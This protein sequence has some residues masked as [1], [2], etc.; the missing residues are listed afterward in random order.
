M[1]S[2]EKIERNFIKE[3]ADAII[4]LNKFRALARE[5]EQQIAQATRNG[6]A[7][8]LISLK[9]HHQELQEQVFLAHTTQVSIQIEE[10]DARLSAA[11]QHQEETQQ[12]YNETV[13]AVAAEV[14]RL[15]HQIKVARL[16]ERDAF[17]ARMTAK[18]QAQTL[19]AQRRVLREERD[20]LIRE[21]TGENRQARPAA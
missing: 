6:D 16:R 1:E 19:L 18:G 14:Q 9:R 4:A 13:S 17:A 20:R 10:M 7:A 2:T 11:D 5:T 8:Q 21:Y 15:E 12:A 3:Q